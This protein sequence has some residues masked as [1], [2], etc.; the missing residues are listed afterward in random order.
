MANNPTSTAPL[1]SQ[2][3]PIAATEPARSPLA[4]ALLGVIIAAFAITAVV[5]LGLLLADAL[6]GYGGLG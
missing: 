5:A 2:P 1:A 4:A 6:V 3:A